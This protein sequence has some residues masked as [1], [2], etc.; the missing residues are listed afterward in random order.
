MKLLAGERK[1]CAPSATKIRAYYS[2]APDIRNPLS[3]KKLSQRPHRSPGTEL[4]FERVIW[5]AAGAVV[6]NNIR[7]KGKKLW[8]DRRRKLIGY[9]EAPTAK[10]SLFIATAFR[11]SA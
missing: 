6:A 9:Y 7:R 5:E 1:T 2:W 3:L 10:R 11:S 8:T 4:S